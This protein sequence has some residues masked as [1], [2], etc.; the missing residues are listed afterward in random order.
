MYDNGIWKGVSAVLGLVILALLIIF[1]PNIIRSCN[2]WNERNIEADYDT[3]WE[4]QKEIE[5]TLRS[6]MASYNAD[7]I[8]FDTASNP[9]TREAAM[10]R[11]NRT[12]AVYNEYY[13]KNSHIWKDRVP[14]DIKSERPMLKDDSAKTDQ[15]SES[16]A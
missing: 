2:S 3:N 14:S 7:K 16:V 9:E 6:Y 5:D 8:T 11:A 1:M 12:A 15:V 4:K 13:L 10:I